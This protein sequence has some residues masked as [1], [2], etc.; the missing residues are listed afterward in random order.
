MGGLIQSLNP[1]QPELEE[2]AGSGSSSPTGNQKAV[3]CE[4]TRTREAVE[5][6]PYL[7]SAPYLRGQPTANAALLNGGVVG[8]VKA[9]VDTGTHISGITTGL[10]ERCQ[11]TVSSGREVGRALSI[12]GDAVEFAGTCSVKMQLG[13]LVLHLDNLA[14]IENR[15]PMLII[16]MDIL[17]G[18][19]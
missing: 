17:S 19:G 11:L 2:Q 1:Q 15:V 12:S 4:V 14:V 3:L 18:Q 16:G 13:T 7:A 6:Y 10:L 5:D 8:R 9:M